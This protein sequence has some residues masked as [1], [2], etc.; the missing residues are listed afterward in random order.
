MGVMVLYDNRLRLLP[1]LETP[2]RDESYIS[3]D[4][5]LRWKMISWW[6]GNREYAVSRLSLEIANKISNNIGLT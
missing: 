2:R 6:L 4:S 5:I 1:N 3:K